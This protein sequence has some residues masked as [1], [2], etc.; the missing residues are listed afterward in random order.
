MDHQIQQQARQQRYQ[1]GEREHNLRRGKLKAKV[2]HVLHC[3]FNL[4]LK[5]T[6]IKF[7]IVFFYYE[8]KFPRR[9]Q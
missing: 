1:Y 8:T 4:N 7:F 5:Q 3:N 2:V 6:V 9:C